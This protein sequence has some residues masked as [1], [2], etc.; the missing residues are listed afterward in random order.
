MQKE[1]LFLNYESNLP[2]REKLAHALSSQK[3]QK[4]LEE[5]VTLKY[6]VE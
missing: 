1:N 3:E 4:L 6:W 5:I 2:N